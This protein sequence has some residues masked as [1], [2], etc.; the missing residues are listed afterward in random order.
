MLWFKW[1][2]ISDKEYKEVLWKEKKKM[3]DSELNYRKYSPSL[4]LYSLNRG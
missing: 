4:L 3:E 1:V 2:N